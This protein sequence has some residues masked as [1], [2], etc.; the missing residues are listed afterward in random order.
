MNTKAG[1]NIV[2]GFTLME[3]MITVA[4]LGVLASLA[5]PSFR[6]F[7]AS[8]RVKTAASDIHVSLLMSRS[9]AVKRGGNVTLSPLTAG[10]WNSGWSIINQ[11]DGSVISESAS[12]SGIAISGPANVTYNGFG[13]TSSLAS[14]AF[15]ITATGTSERRCVELGTTS[16]LPTVKRSGCS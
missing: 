11:A 2:K 7:I 12:R 3:L 10:Q 15:D 6:E 4:I 13:R 16:G 1:A 5:A 9:E 8:Q 14:V